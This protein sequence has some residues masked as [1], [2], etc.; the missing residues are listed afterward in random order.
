MSKNV[1]IYSMFLQWALSQKSERTDDTKNE[2]Y[3]I[4]DF[5]EA[6]EIL[7]PERE[8]ERELTREFVKCILPDYDKN[9]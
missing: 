3:L 2:R 8:K 7:N 9:M 4:D 1:R 5:L 6:D